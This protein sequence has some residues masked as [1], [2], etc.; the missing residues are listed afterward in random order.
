[1][2]AEGNKKSQDWLWSRPPSSFFFLFFLL[3][4]WADKPAVPGPTR[5]RAF[6]DI[7]LCKFSPVHKGNLRYLQSR[8]YLPYG[9]IIV[10]LWLSWQGVLCIGVGSHYLCL[11]HP[12]C[13]HT[14]GQPPL[15][16]N[17]RQHS[18]LTFHLKIAPPSAPSDHE[19]MSILKE[20]P[21]ECIDKRCFEESLWIPERVAVSVSVV[22]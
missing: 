4:A 3:S 8:L 6:V 10:S 11:L 13:P 17:M 2:S 9:T 7:V 1:M 19:R 20:I 15:E 16:Y 12:S 14:A 5:G 22:T 18:Q 21:Q